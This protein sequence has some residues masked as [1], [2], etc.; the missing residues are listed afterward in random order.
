MDPNATLNELLELANKAVSEDGADSLDGERM[1][2]LIIS[3]DNWI[4][5]GGFLPEPWESPRGAG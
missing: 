4:R 5:N 1:G 3:L 2:E